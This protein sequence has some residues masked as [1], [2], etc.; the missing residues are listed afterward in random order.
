MAKSIF[1]QILKGL[2]FLHTNQSAHR[3]IKLD[4]ILISDNGNIKIADFGEAKICETPEDDIYKVTDIKELGALLYILLNPG[5]LDFEAAIQYKI[6]D[7]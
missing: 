4:N 7:G 2:D 1:K 3:D 6:K 5:S